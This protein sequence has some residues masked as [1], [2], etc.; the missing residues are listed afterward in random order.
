MD[1]TK[2]ALQAL[3]SYRQTASSVADGF[4]RARQGLVDADVSGD[5]FGLLQE[6]QGIAGK[7]SERCEAGLQ[8]LTDGRDVFDAL[9]DAMEAVRDAYRTADK[10]AAQ[11]YGGQ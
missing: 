10:A 7:Y 3:D 6:S 8:V 9:A 4:D 11:R 1:T 2:I 5:S